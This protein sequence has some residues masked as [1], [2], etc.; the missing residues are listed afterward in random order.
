MKILKRTKGLLRFRTTEGTIV[1][2]L[3]K[4]Q[5]KKRSKM[6]LKKNLKRLLKKQSKKIILKKELIF[7]ILILKLKTKKL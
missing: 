6:K 5:K 2:S 3:K 1:L 4:S 7:L